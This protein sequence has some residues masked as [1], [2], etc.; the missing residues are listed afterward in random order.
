MHRSRIGVV[1]IDHPES[2]WE[3]GLAFWA[4]VQGVDQ[5][6]GGSPY[7]SLGQIGSVALESQRIGDGTPAR[8]HLDIEKRRRTPPKWRVWSASARP[9]SRSVRATP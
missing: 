9:W 2:D 8:I 5:P 3:K 6:K 1:L 7:R 4:G